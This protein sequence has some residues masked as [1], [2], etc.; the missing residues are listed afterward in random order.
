MKANLTARFL[1]RKAFEYEALNHEIEQ[2]RQE[3]ES[4]QALAP[5]VSKPVVTVVVRS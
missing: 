4:A 1:K 5:E 3:L 2:L